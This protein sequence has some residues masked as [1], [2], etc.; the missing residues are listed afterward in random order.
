MIQHDGRSAE[1]KAEKYPNRGY[2][3]IAKPT[4]IT[5][6]VTCRVRLPFTVNG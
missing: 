5:K 4:P 2:V 6:S 1:G 3:W